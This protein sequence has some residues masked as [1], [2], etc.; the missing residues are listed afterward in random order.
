MLQYTELRVHKRGV[1][2]E[3]LLSLSSSICPIKDT[4]VSLSLLISLR[5]DGRDHI[6]E[7]ISI[8]Y[9]LL[10]KEGWIQFHRRLKPVL[11]E[12]MQ[13]TEDEQR[14]FKLVLQGG[15]A[16]INLEEI[17]FDLKEDPLLVTF[18]RNEDSNKIEEKVMEQMARTVAKDSMG[19]K[20][21]I[22]VETPKDNSC[23]L[24]P[25]NVSP[26]IT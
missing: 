10:L 24:H 22:V 9:D 1:T 6:L 7:T 17:G 21:R 26:A 25:Y 11:S 15:C 19:R 16:G 8:S 3:R 5:S 13:Q 23:K 4:G 12:W 2:H 14:T 20:K 18:V